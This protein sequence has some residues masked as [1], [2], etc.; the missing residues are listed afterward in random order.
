MAEVKCSNVTP[1]MNK[2]CGELP[3]RETTLPK[4]TDYEKSVIISK[5]KHVIAMDI[6]KLRL[7]N[8]NRKLTK[9]A[10]RRL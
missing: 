2:E 9:N 6:F 3:I 1:P 5:R 4:L 10:Y 7:Y 8:T